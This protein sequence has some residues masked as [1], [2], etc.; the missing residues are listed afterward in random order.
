MRKLYYEPALEIECF[1]AENI[2]TSS[3][4]V[5]SQETA[6][7]MAKKMLEEAGATVITQVDLMTY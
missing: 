3:G 7:D 1:A 5:P 4:V 2:I 6:Q